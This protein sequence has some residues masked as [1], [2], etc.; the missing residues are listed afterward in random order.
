MAAVAAMSVTSFASASTLDRVYLLGN[1]D[2]GAAN[3]GAVTVT[4]DSQGELGMGEL[5]DLTAVNTPTY[6]TINGRPDGGGG[7]G[8]EF[9]AAQQ[10]YLHGFSLGFPQDS[11]SASTHTTLTGGSL[12]YTGISDRGFQFWARPSATTAQ[13]LVM[14][15][16]RHGVRI[17]SSGNYSMRYNGVDYDSG[18][19]V[20]AGQWSHIMVVRPAGAAN[21]S[22]MYINGVARVVAP[23]GYGNDWADLTIGASTAGDDGGVVHDEIPDPVGFMLGTPPEFYSGII[24]DLEMFVM[25][26]TPPPDD[27]NYGNLN[28]V[29]ENDFIASP[30]S[31]LSGLPGDV[32]NNNQFNQADKT[33]FIAGWM[34]RRMVDGFQVG[35][36]V[37]LGQGD[38]NL[39]GITDI[40]DLL[41]IQGAL[42]GAGLGTITAAELAG[43]P[44]PSAAL[45]AIVAAACALVAQRRRATRCA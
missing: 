12:N 18:V 10:E 1:G 35:D 45:L 4:L 36:M 39:D 15:T 2:P 20:T 26:V 8:I 21:G 17:N 7:L 9:N 31:G 24:D 11:F 30:V 23:G 14:D 33:A 29:V 42:S 28:L 40:K 25:G 13:T 3:H 19:L 27:I 32:T 22:R 44:E 37:S 6:R 38:L 41:L 34:D 5:V 43:V 16:N